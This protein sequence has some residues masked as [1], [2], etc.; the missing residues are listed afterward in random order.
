M[1]LIV[2]SGSGEVPFELQR[3][4]QEG[5]P[6]DGWAGDPNLYLRKCCGDACRDNFCGG[7]ALLRSTETGH[8]KPIAHFKG[9]DL[10]GSIIQMLAKRSKQTADEFVDE[11]ESNNAAIRAAHEQHSD[12]AAQS[13]ADRLY[14]HLR[15]Q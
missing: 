1:G 13:A 12:E 2:P 4:L 14:D 15:R 5:S 7:W 11:I 6:V 10:N 9:A 3:K 8:S